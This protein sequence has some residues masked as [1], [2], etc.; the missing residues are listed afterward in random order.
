MRNMIQGPGVHVA[1]G[2]VCDIGWGQSSLTG[3]PDLTAHRAR[4]EVL[5][6]R[7][8]FICRWCS[9]QAV[10]FSDCPIGSEM[11]LTFGLVYPFPQGTHQGL[12]RKQ[13]V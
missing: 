13:E 6:N 1:G 11:L 5:G 12:K 2:S 7:T 10:A 3:L 4:G 8:G 9:S